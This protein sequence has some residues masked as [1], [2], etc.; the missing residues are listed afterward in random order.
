MY[1]MR[2]YIYIAK[3]IGCD[4]IYK[5]GSS[6]D[7]A[8][9]VRSL[10]ADYKSGFELVHKESLKGYNSELDIHKDLNE[11]KS[12]FFGA[13]RREIFKADYEVILSSVQRVNTQ[14]STTHEYDHFYHQI[15]FGSY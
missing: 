1:R 15:K 10:K 8:K 12:D 3:A 5:V 7:P 6:Y 2:K 14:E 4:D 13:N 9:R 11:Y